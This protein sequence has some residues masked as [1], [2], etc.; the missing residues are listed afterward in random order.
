MT[1]KSTKRPRRTSARKKAAPK[2]PAPTPAAEERL[3]TVVSVDQDDAVHV[4]IFTGGQGHDI[5]LFSSKKVF[6]E[7]VNGLNQAVQ[8][9]PAFEDYD[10]D[11]EE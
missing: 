3:A 1:T 2:P 8:K 7:F 5:A 11:R 4:R 10:D 6:F 9:H